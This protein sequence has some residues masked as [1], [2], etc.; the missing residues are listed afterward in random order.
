MTESSDSIYSVFACN[1]HVL[2]SDVFKDLAVVDI[3]D[4]LVIPDFGGQQDGSQ[5]DAL[6]VGGA[7]IQLSVGQQALQVHLD[8]GVFKSWKL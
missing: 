5:D 8:G 4:S 7:D 1:S 2:H 3:P 6:P